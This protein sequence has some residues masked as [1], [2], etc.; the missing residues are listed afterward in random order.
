MNGFPRARERRQAMWLDV[1]VHF[2]CYCQFAIAQ[3][4]SSS[5]KN[6]TEED[7]GHRVGPGCGGGCRESYA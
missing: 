1:S 3:T 6:K 7:V 4:V 5:L 2:R